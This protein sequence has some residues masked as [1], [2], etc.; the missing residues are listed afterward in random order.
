MAYYSS[1]VV[2]SRKTVMVFQDGACFLQKRAEVRKIYLDKRCVVLSEDKRIRLSGRSSYQV[3][4]TLIPIF[5]TSERKERTPKPG[6]SSPIH[7]PTSLISNP[8]PLPSLR[9][10]F[11]PQTPIH[12][13]DLTILAVAIIDIT[14]PSIILKPTN[15][16]CRTA[17]R[18]G[19]TIGGSSR[20]GY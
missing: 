5:P 1:E 4:I 20:G 14:T 16:Q 12:T 15:Q 17:T 18:A 13:S 9:P 8:C 10:Q 7:Q 6:I 19:R 2:R 3:T 11:N